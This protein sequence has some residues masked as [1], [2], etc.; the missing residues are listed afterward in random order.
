MDST[1]RVS[2][3]GSSKLTAAAAGG[4]ALVSVA[5]TSWG[6]GGA[7]APHFYK[8]LGRGHHEYV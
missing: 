6:T 2:L 4:E 1:V 7:G 8:W 3:R 5:P